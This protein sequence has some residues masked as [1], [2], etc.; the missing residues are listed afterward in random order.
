MMGNE[1]DHTLADCEAAK[2]TEEAK[3]TARTGG[4]RLLSAVSISGGSFAK[5]RGTSDHADR[6]MSQR[7]K[8]AARPNFDSRFAQARR[9]LADCAE[10]L[11]AAPTPEER[12]RLDTLRLEALAILAELDCTQKR[13]RRYRSAMSPERRV[14]DVLVD[15]W[16][17]HR[18]GELRALGFPTQAIFTRARVDNGSGQGSPMS[19]DIATVDAAIAQLRPWRRNV[20]LHRHVAWVDVQHAARECQ[21]SVSQF[22]RQM[23]SICDMLIDL[24]QPLIEAGIRALQLVGDA[25]QS[26]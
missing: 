9:T 23:D 26:R 15:R 1:V 21:L 6:R 18:V 16:V 11:A 3:Q 5:V 24:L 7:A 14:L 20:L 2:A 4:N 17:Q 10:R 13:D 25:R 12:Q 19:E 8:G 22:Q